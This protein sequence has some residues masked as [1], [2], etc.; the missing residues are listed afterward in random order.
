LFNTRPLVIRMATRFPILLAG[1]LLL[2]CAAFVTPLPGQ[3]TDP[4]PSAD[5]A[6]DGSGSIYGDIAQFGGPS[7][8][9]GQL[10]EDA[11]VAPQFRLQ[12]LQD[13]FEPWY[14]FKE[15]VDKRFGL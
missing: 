14:D 7:S 12:R 9:G 6:S 2:C 5:N 11:T 3:D 15:R 1:L 8:V 4:T 10:A 13:R